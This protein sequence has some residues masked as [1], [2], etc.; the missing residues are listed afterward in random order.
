MSQNV[1]LVTVD[2]L[3]ADRTGP[4]SDTMPTLTA[5][6]DRGVSYEQAFS[7]GYSTPV[8][9]P[10][11]LTGTYP[12]Q[13]GGYQYMSDRRPF[14]ARHLADHG[15]HTAAFHS[16][17]HLRAERNYDAG[18]D[19][20]AGFEATTD[21]GSSLR[22]LVTER[23]DSDSRL[24][25]FLR[26]AYHLFRSSGSKD[27]LT[28]P[29]INAR[30]LRWLDET[31]D[32][33]RPFF[34]WNHYMDVHYP[35]YPPDEYVRAPG[36]GSIPTSRRLK[37]NGRMHEDPSAMTERDRRDLRALYDGEVR[38]MDDHL[39]RL[40]DEL[41]SR[42]LLGDTLVVV[43]SDH[44]E[45]FGEYGQYGHPPLLQDELM[46]IP[47]VLTGPTVTSGTSVARQTALVDLAPTVSSLLGFDSDSAWVGQDTTTFFNDDA[48][49][50]SRE[51]I[52]GDRTVIGCQTSE[53][54]LIQWVDADGRLNVSDEWELWDRTTNERVALD[55][56]TDVVGRLRD[57]LSAYRELVQETE[58]RLPEV[59]A[60]DDVENRLEAL[61]YR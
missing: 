27:Y 7:N 2:S 26:R 50:E 41:A 11:I 39:G 59:E 28:A 22:F 46:R 53:W 20:Y 8:S 24:Y 12:D 36:D 34:L 14:L 6:A 48:A 49:A 17:P 58:E 37:L 1:V 13:Y 29:K 38:Y 21:T 42:D 33:T 10:A 25:A 45:L 56:H 3:R 30:A 40:L 55:D 52:L 57:S 4:D 44:G 18:F 47:L 9:F 23:L 54:R 60:D 51:L 5:L 43:T 16:N 61:G 31:W 32:T 15:Y 35:F 19:D